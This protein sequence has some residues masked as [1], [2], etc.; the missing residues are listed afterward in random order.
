MKFWQRTIFLSVAVGLTACSGTG[1]QVQSDE[2]ALRRIVDVYIEHIEAY[3]PAKD[4]SSLPRVTQT[5][6]IFADS[7]AVLARELEGVAQG[8]VYEDVEARRKA[9]KVIDLVKEI[10]EVMEEAVRQEVTAKGSP[11]ARE[12]SELH[13]ELIETLQ[14]M[15]GG[16]RV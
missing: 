4:Y 11:Y 13:R 5:F 12:Y 16:D 10:R 15:P 9:V 14:T 6:A 2:E 1:K 7:Y 8:H 3:Q